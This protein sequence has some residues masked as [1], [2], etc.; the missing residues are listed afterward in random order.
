MVI[1]LKTRKGMLGS[2]PS[3]EL[4]AGIISAGILLTT[5]LSFRGAALSGLMICAL[6]WIWVCRTV[7]DPP[8]RMVLARVLVGREETRPVV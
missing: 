8:V 7:I 2:V 6:T 1:L 5:G 3:P 4:V